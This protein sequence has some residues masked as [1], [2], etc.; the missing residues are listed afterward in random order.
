MGLR[1]EEQFGEDLDQAGEGAGFASY[2]DDTL[3]EPEYAP[4]PSAISS[5]VKAGRFAIIALALGWIGFA[6]YL[7]VQRGFRMP[8]LE[9]IPLAAAGISTPLILLGILY[10]I[11]VRG[12][13][14]EADRFARISTQLRTEADA[15]D[16]RLAIV[17][18]QLDTARQTLRDQASLLEE[19]GGAASQNLEAA[20]RTLTQHAS[21]SAQQAEIIERAGLSLATQFGRLVDAMPDVETRTNRVASALSLGSDTLEEKV[22]RLEARLD[23]L[24]RM[25]DEART[26]TTTT[27][28]SLTAQLMRIQDATRSAS[29]EVTGMADISANRIDAAIDIARRAI[30]EAGVALDMRSTELNMLVEQ[31]RSSLGAIGGQAVLAYGESIAQIETRLRELDTL[32]QDRAEVIG[33][34]TRTMSLR[35]ETLSDEFAQLQSVGVTSS[36]RMA[37]AMESLTNRTQKLDEALESGNR[38]AEGMIA[39]TEGLLTALDASVREMDEGHPAALARLNDKIDS[40]QRLLSV[41]MPE[42]EHLES[43]S[44]SVLGHARESEELLSGQQRKLRELLHSGENTLAGCREQ[45]DALNL[46]IESADTG[47]RRLSDSAG[48]QMV[49]TLLRIKDT[50]EQAGERAKEALFNAIAEAGSQI[51]DASEQAM[52]ERLGDV[53]RARIEEVSNVAERA[54]QAAH[55]A[56]DRLMRQLI[57]IADTTA[58]IEQRIAEADE[59]AQKREQDSFSHQSATLIDSLNSIAID[60]TKILSGEVSDT[61]WAAYLKG[62]RG[63]FSRRAVRLIDTAQAQQIWALYQRDAGFHDGVNR[64]IHDFEAMLRAILPTRDGSSIA[65]T[66]LSSDIGKLYV[67]LAQAIDRLK[68]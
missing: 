31:S 57:T 65:V 44:A 62:D 21:T 28:Q 7:L 9:Q 22:D 51:G 46:A 61:L 10:L 56:S 17:N 50:A 63:V 58:A 47:A 45:V 25:L 53:F 15:L 36:E 6:A 66:L 14:G 26:R 30:D 32:V 64:Y 55:A 19:Y 37:E 4:E 39:R 1:R 16:M 33:D 13:M 3:I 11:L 12:S 40:S 54:V 41:I 42:I 29:E 8:G 43:M 18:Q 60:V 68:D 23:S 34:I 52:N 59:A 67:A 35:I 20:A 48:P 49:A 38:A 2:A 24:G 27:T 5:W